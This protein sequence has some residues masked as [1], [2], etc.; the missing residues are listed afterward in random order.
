MP[1]LNEAAILK[2]TLETLLH[3]RATIK[4]SSLTDPLPARQRHHQRRNR[5]PSC[6]TLMAVAHAT[7]RTHFMRGVV[8]IHLCLCQHFIVAHHA[9]VLMLQVVTVKDILARKVGKMH[10]HFHTLTRHNEK[11]VLPTLVHISRSHAVPPCF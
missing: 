8:T 4:S 3:R 1:V 7:P 9:H 10:Q 6:H 5:L 11:S 2:A